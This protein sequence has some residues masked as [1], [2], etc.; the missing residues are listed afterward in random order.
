MKRR[1]V[2]LLMAVLCVL[3]WAAIPA[4][5]ETKDNAGA[6]RITGSK[7]V[8]VGKKIT[9]EADTSAAVQWSSSNKKVATV[10]KT[11]V[12]KGVKAGTAT[13]TARTAKGKEAT[14]KVTVKAKA[15]QSVKITAK[16]KTLDLK[17]KK[18]VALQ[19]KASPSAA[20]QS[21]TWKSSNKKVATVSSSGKVTAKGTGTVI[22]TATATDGSKKKAT[23]QLTVKG[24]GA[25][26]VGVSLPTDA[27]QRWKSDGESIKAQLE[28]AGYQVDLKF[29][30]NDVST[31]EQ[32]VAAMVE[33][34]CE[35][36]VVSAINGMLGNGALEAAKAN[37]V[38]VIAYDR[39]LMDTD[40]VS[41]YVTFDNVKVGKLQGNYIKN[42]LKLDSTD[43]PYNIEFTAGD[44][45]DM[46][47]AKFYKGAISVL[48]P[49]LDSGVLVSKSGQTKFEEVTTVGWKTENAADRAMNI[50]SSYYADGDTI[51]AWMCSNDST[52][53]G[54]IN[55]LEWCYPGNGW[56]VITGQDCDRYNVKM[57]LQGK[58]AMSVFKDTSILVSR[59]VKMVRQILEGSSVDTN[60][61]TNN[62]VINV[63]SYL[64][65]P[66]AVDRSNYKEYLIDSGL[67]TEEDFL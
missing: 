34:G 37:G 54:V 35:V 28:K 21:F 36:I 42:A 58:Q 16:T 64:C 33:A 38:A 48:Q 11:G 29:A 55:A 62:N 17:N 7:F 46:N 45:G 63:P 65:A 22:I 53:A 59:T 47:A 67:Y 39:L 30:D 13:I 10:S 60:G 20:A 3:S 6:F 1:L 52:A 43:G 49:Y 23:I 44:P 57:I 50:I 24:G 56:P 31:Q 4:G 51:D 40:A 14:W 25:G 9:L 5:A 8:A 2:A 61:K 19:A 12:V 18:T 27:L 26:R 15:V 66:V 32:Q 41:Y